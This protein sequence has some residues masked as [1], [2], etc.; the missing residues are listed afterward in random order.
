VC[1][2]ETEREREYMAVVDIHN[3]H[4]EEVS[5]ERDRDRDETETET[6]RKKRRK[7]GKR[8]RRRCLLE[9]T[10]GFC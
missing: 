8:S 3:A 10:R 6:E 5:G 1:E 4:L 7:K 2:R 9:P